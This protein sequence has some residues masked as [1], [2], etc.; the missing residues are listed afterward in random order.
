MDIFLSPFF[1]LLAVPRMLSEQEMP[2]ASN[3]WC[4]RFFLVPPFLPPPANQS[5]SKM[6]SISCTW[7]GVGMLNVKDESIVDATR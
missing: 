4:E 7:L 5:V 2:S 3:Y 6:I 1:A